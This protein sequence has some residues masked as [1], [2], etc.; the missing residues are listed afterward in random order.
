M[1]MRA[2][3]AAPR[4]AAGLALALLLGRAAGAERVERFYGYAFELDS[5]RFLYTEAHRQRYDGERWLGGEVRYVDA[6]G[7]EFARKTLDFS[8][9]PYV[10]T[11][12]LEV[13]GDGY[14]EGITA[15]AG[16]DVQLIKR[17]RADAPLRRRELALDG[18]L[19]A[20]AGFNS[21][22]LDHL[23]AL[24]RG[25]TLA[26]R[27]IAAGRLDAYRLRVREL[28]DT[29]FEGR[30]AVRLQAEPDSLLR[31]LVA[32]LQLVYDPERRRLL[33]YRGPSN[34]HDPASGA[35]WN[36]RVSFSA[37]PPAQALPL[38]PP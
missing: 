5:G 8:A 18:T 23:D 12:R 20:D 10:P 33:E 36:V 28:G 38:P 22:L 15:V 34:V 29:Q 26:F 37:Q 14:L 13:P 27:F 32:P 17:E 19:A 21:L 11:Y 1:P 2:S 24:R 31:L 9:S 7:R 4:Y 3:R 35:S 6:Q 16:R 25:A 30:P